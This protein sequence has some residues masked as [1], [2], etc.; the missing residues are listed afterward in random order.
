MT[1]KRPMRDDVCMLE[2]NISKITFLN[3]YFFNFSLEEVVFK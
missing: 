1:I 3:Y 2:N